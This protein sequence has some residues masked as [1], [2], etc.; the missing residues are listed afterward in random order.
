MLKDKVALITGSSRGIGKAI[1]LL[2][3]KEGA[4]IAVVYHGNDKAAENTV[5]EIT[6][7]GVKAKAYKADVSSFT[8][9]KD[10]V[11]QIKEDFSRID[12]LV[13]NAGIVKDGLI[14]MMSEEQFSAVIDT[15]LKGAFN[16]IRHTCP[17][18]IRQKCGNI[19]NIASVSGIIGNPG[20]ANYSA[21]KAG[22]IGLTKTCAKELASKNILSNAIA[23]GFIKTDMTE[24][25]TSDNPLVSLIPLKR[26]GE[27]E[28]VAKAALFLAESTY[29]TGQ[30][31]KVDGGIAM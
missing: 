10:T 14:A 12:I 30:V 18:M 5:E 29:I 16:M 11:K 15:N 8:E 24:E 28:E 23:P 3:A 1:A 4:N 17:I 26:F 6:A 25:I 22:I 13:N 27:A 21:S 31:L 7:L 9:A 2:F 20:Q 19:I